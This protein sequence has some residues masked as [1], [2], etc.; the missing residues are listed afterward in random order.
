MDK[1]S[2]V[3]ASAQMTPDEYTPFKEDNSK[4]LIRKLETNMN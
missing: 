1:R 2:A 4:A 3:H